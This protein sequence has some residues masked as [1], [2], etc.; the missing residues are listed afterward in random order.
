MKIKILYCGD[1]HT[2]VFNYCN[3]RQNKF[4]FDVCVVSGAIAY[5]RNEK[6]VKQ[7]STIKRKSKKYL[8]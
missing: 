7:P 8:D 3:S 5:D 1:S 2:R 4:V 6:Y